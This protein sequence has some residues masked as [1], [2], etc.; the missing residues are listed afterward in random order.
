[1]ISAVCL[2]SSTGL[3]TLARFHCFSNGISDAIPSGDDGNVLASLMEV[4]NHF[5]LYLVIHHFMEFPR[6]DSVI[7]ISGYQNSLPPSLPLSVLLFFVL[8]IKFHVVNTNRKQIPR[9]RK[10]DTIWIF[11]QSGVSTCTHICTLFLSGVILKSFIK[12]FYI[13][14]ICNIYIYISVVCLDV[15]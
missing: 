10:S 5:P 4:L 14:E 13:A 15:G 9:I 6:L 12:C 8:W 2:C 1:M 7:K 3:L 11:A